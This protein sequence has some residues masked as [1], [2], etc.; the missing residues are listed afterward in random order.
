[1]CGE[2]GYDSNDCPKNENTPTKLGMILVFR[3]IVIF[4]LA[5]IVNLTKQVASR[6]TFREESQKVTKKLAEVQSKLEEL[7]SSAAAEAKR[8]RGIEASLDSLSREA[9]ALK[10]MLRGLN[11]VRYFCFWSLIYHHLNLLSD[12]MQW[13]HSVRLIPRN[14]PRHF[15]PLMHLP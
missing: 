11:Q 4:L 13:I 10:G 6:N 5:W 9:R 7:R 8:M 2:P 12:P 14:T 1:M 3:V 15:Q